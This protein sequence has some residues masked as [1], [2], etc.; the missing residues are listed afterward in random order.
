MRARY[1]LVALVGTAL[2]AS[3]AGC[4]RPSSALSPLEVS[5]SS[6]VIVEGQSRELVFG[7]PANSGTSVSTYKLVSAELLEPANV[8]LEA[9]YV[10]LPGVPIPSAQ[11]VADF[12][13]TAPGISALTGFEFESNATTIYVL[14]DVTGTLGTSATGFG[15]VRLT[16]ETPIGTQRQ[17]D[18]SGEVVFDS[19]CSPEDD[20]DSATSVA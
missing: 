19:A 11:D 9:T 15:G 16:Y 14:V 17:L 6:C 5:F 1:W 20:A 8:Q 7:F 3:L 4:S 13:A 18:L 10:Q 2:S 12:D